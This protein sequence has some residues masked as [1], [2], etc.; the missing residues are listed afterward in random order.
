MVYELNPK[1][2][3]SRKVGYAHYKV[4]YNSIDYSNKCHLFYACEQLAGDKRDGM[5]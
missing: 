2:C 1:I 4:L 5:V 3:L